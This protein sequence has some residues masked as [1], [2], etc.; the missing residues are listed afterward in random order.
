MC[1]LTARQLTELAE[2]L[3]CILPTGQK[4]VYF[5]VDPPFDRTLPW[6]QIT[7]TGTP[8]GGIRY[9]SSG[10]W[11]EGAVS[12]G[13]SGFGTGPAG[14]AGPEGL[15][16][17]PGP[18]GPEGP[19]GLTGPEGPAGAD[20]PEGP[21]GADGTNGE[22]GADGAT[23]ATGPAGPTGATGPPGSVGN[24]I[25]PSVASPTNTRP[26]V[27]EATT[28]TLLTLMYKGTDNVVRTATIV[29]A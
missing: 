15:E 23:G 13:G 3:Q 18:A 17:P 26:F 14:P 27:I 10:T 21:A 20:G 24:L 6:Q 25:L 5:G 4:L 29:V 11:P 28:N 2:A 1:G 9:Y 19:I 12:G 22:D 8:I 16:G 7:V